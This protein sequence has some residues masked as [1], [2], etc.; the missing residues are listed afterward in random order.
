MFWPEIRF[1]SL[2]AQAFRPVCSRILRDI[3]LIGDLAC[4][5]LL[6]APRR[7]KALQILDLASI[8]GVLILCRQRTV[9][10]F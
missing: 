2:R 1:R 3:S 5:S 8:S 10:V 7:Q 6:L 9:H 4:I